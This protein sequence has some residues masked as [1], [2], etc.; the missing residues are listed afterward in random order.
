MADAQ[1][2]HPL[3][4]QIDA[5]SRSVGDGEIPV[6]VQAEWRVEDAVDIP[7]ATYVLRHSR[8]LGTRPPFEGPRLARERCSSRDRRI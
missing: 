8:C 7:A 3:G 5:E 6:L 4:V 2:R 1:R